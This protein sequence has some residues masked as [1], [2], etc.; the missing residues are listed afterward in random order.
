MQHQLIKLI[1]LTN[2]NFIMGSLNGDKV[3]NLLR[4]MVCAQSKVVEISFQQ[5]QGVDACFIRNSIASFAKMMC[6]QTGVMVSD[7]E[8]IDISEN[9]MYGFK[10]KDMPLL[11]K[12]SDELATIFSAVPCGVKDI[13]SHS[14]TQN[15]TTTE[16]IAKKFG[17]SSPNAS[18]KL[19]KLH[20]NGYLLA[21]K[22]EARTGGLEY[23]FKPIFKCN[24]LNFQI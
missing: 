5:M 10:A 3:L 4:S 17:L 16:Q 6:G 23:V 11:I 24:K 1:D 19:K 22:R 21:E 14:Y 12:H 8:N 15:E 7:V 20:K 13:L 18:A 9:L 2:T